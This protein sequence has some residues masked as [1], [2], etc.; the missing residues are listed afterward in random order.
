[1]MPTQQIP[2]RLSERA[3][4]HRVRLCDNGCKRWI[5]YDDQDNQFHDA[6]YS[7]KDSLHKDSCWVMNKAW[8][9]AG[10]YNWYP[11]YAFLH[12]TLLLISKVKERYRDDT[13]EY[14]IAVRLKKSLLERAAENEKERTKW[15]EEKARIK[16]DQQNRRF[17]RDSGLSSYDET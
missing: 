10:S 5:Y 16:A 8:M 9:I 1:M 7:R 6:E 11:D 17:K 13:E 14:K 3:K 4:K 12:D 2:I 15:K